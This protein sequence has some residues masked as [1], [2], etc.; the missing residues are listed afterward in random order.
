MGSFLRQPGLALRRHLRTRSRGQSLVEFAL[1]LPVTLLLLAMGLDFGRVFL[2]WVNLNNTARI[3]A[4]FAAANAEKMF[5]NDP[6]TF[7][8]YYDQIQKDATAINCTLPAKALFPR[9]TF[10]LGTTIGKTASVAISC[11]FGIITPLISNVLGSPLTVSASAVFPIRT[12]AVAGVPAGG[13]P[14]PVAAFNITP[15]GGTAPVDIRFTDV[16]TNSPT[17][18]SWDFNGDGLI[19]STDS[20][21]VP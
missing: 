2:G 6:T 21:P 10:P 20:A 18:Y 3:A 16:S 17:T 4:N 8:R 13:L 1:I 5:L 11:K 7:D 12:G 15:A 9:P 19:D 14:K